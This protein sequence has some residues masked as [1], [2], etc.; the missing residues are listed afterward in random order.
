MP[1]VKTP[2]W[3]ARM[4]DLEMFNTLSVSFSATFLVK[5]LTTLHF[6]VVRGEHSGQPFY[7]KKHQINVPRVTCYLNMRHMI[8]SFYNF[9]EV[10]HEVGSP[11][12][13]PG[14]VRI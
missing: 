8:F 13:N 1:V 9:T 6:D 11:E 4:T 2:P 7:F 3:K 5:P 12:R 14:F 10:S